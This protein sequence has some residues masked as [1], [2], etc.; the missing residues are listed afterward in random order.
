MRVNIFSG[1]LTTLHSEVLVVSCF[2]D[3]RPLRGLA[4]EVDWL[5][6]GILSTLLM[7]GK[8]TGKLGEILL[9]ATQQ[10]M[11]VPK[12]VLAGLGP[13]AAYDYS[14][15]SSVAKKVFQTIVGFQAREC[16]VE[17]PMSPVRPLDCSLLVEAFLRGME[18]IRRIEPFDLTFVVKDGEKARALQQ[19]IKNGTYVRSGALSAVRVEHD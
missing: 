4:G 10:K 15:F 18:E 8:V 16:A 1:K 13:S 3:I 19:M 12:V 5:Y 11:Q 2:E 9:L 6:G 17:L 7:R 14:Y